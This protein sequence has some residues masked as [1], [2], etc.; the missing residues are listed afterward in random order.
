MGFEVQQIWWGKTGK[1]HTE[2]NSEQSVPLSL[3]RGRAEW[4]SEEVWVGSRR[5]RSG[6]GRG[7]RDSSLPLVST[8][9]KEKGWFP[10]EKAV[11]RDLEPT[12]G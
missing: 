3:G 11:I 9:Q 12:L 7:S 8:L 10:P 4:G 6:K 2:R 5:Q 1:A